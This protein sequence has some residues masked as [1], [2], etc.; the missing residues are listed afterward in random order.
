M[1]CADQSRCRRTRVRSARGASVLSRCSDPV[2]HA[3]GCRICGVRLQVL[4]DPHPS[5]CGRTQRL[6]A[7]RIKRSSHPQSDG[8]QLEDSETV[9]CWP[10]CCAFPTEPGPNLQLS[11]AMPSITVALSRPSAFAWSE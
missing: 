11:A 4:A 1:L 2:R 6:A 10:L 9:F 7:C 5:T 8:Y 3:V